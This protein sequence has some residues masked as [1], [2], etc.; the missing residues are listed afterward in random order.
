MEF[1]N[2]QDLA[3]LY[4]HRGTEP[5][6]FR[7]G[8]GPGNLPRQGA[9]SA[10]AGQRRRCLPCWAKQTTGI[11]P[12]AAAQTPPPAPSGPATGGGERV[13]GAAR[14]ALGGLA[15]GAIAGDAGEGAAIGAV[16][17]TMA[18]G[19]RA[20]QNQ[21]AQQQQVQSQQQQQLQTYYRAYGACMEGRGYTIK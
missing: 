12:L 6:V 13:S 16:V 5:G 2:A 8:A 11:D 4:R 9:K 10:A 1:S 20:R 14:G 15:I 3:Y 17:G 19:H 18:G 21:A 7:H